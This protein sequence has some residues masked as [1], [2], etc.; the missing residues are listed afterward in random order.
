MNTRLRELAKEAGVEMYQDKVL[1][2]GYLH[3][4]TIRFA[5]L[6]IKDSIKILEQGISCSDVARGNASD[7]DRGI[8]VG[9]E[10][11]IYAIEKHFQVSTGV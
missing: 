7:Y 6:I 10:L 9:L 11:A 1:N 4:D 5:E 2:L 8:L 3:G